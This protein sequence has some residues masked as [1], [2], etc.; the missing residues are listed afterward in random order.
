MFSIEKVQHAKNKLK[1]A[2]HKSGIW[3]FTAFIC[4]CI[5]CRH[6]SLYPLWKQFQFLNEM[7]ICN[8]RKM[9]FFPFK[10]FSFLSDLSDMPT[11]ITKTVSADTRFLTCHWR[12]W[13]F[14]HT[15]AWCLTTWSGAAMVSSYFFQWPCI[16]G[17]DFTKGD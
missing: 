10:F 14:Y 4:I 16:T 6:F 12:R 13:Q 2:I 15:L 11:H 1:T 8:Y 3:V 9:H 7:S 17:P 5:M